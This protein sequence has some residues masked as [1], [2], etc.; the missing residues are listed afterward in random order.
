VE[1]AKAGERKLKGINNLPDKG[2]YP[3]LKNGRL[4]HGC[5]HER[6]RK[7]EFLRRFMS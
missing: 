1:K 3:T 2:K 4:P 6:K 7:E 5:Q